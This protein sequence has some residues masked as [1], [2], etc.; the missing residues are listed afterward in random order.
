APIFDAIAS[1]IIGLLLAATAIF[2]AYETRGLLVGEAADRGLVKSV[3]AIAAAD[4]GVA[5][6]LQALTM[7]LGPDQ[8][9]LDLDVVFRSELRAAEVAE[10][11]D[12]IERA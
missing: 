1:M 4:A 6:V 5:R 10:S 11:I 2:L 9:L 12:R 8:V 7:Q 3:R